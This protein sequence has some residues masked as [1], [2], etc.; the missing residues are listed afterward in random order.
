MSKLLLS[1]AI[2]A[3]ALAVMTPAPAGAQFTYDKL[4]YLTFTGM[5]QVPGATLAAGTYRFHVTNPSTSRNVIQVLSYNGDTVYAMFHTLP[6]LRTVVTADPVVTFTEVPADVPPPIKT[7]FYNG[8]SIGYQF[9]YGPGADLTPYPYPQPPVTY[10]ASV[11]PAVAP[12]VPRIE[13]VVEPEPVFTP[14][15]PVALAP[16]DVPPEF[17]KTATQLPA[18][19][20]G[21][22]LLVI[23]G[24]GLA[25]A[26]RID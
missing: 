10:T 5:V 23:A 24:L 25:L 2:L 3:T 18:V 6:D 7:L 20:F 14:S 16:A 19:A 11:A 22:V 8:E 21:G 13:P 9:Q 12:P 17:P 15:E 26:R 4:T 1:S